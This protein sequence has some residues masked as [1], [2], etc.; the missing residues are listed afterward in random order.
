MSV[1]MD[2]E[3][4]SILYRFVCKPPALLQ[5]QVRYRLRRLASREVAYTV[6]NGT[7]NAPRGV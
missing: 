2:A 6:E 7:G 4:F 5:T 1:E 3:S